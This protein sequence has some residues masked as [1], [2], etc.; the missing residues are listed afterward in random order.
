VTID[1]GDGRVM[2]RT[3]T[4]NSI[5]YV[6]D[7]QARPIDALPGLYS[8]DMFIKKLNAALKLHSQL[9]GPDRDEKLAAWHRAAMDVKEEVTPQLLAP[10]VRLVIAA[11]APPAEKAEK[12]TVSKGFVETP[13]IAS[14]RR[15]EDSIAQ[16]TARNEN[17]LHHQIHAWFA[18]RTVADWSGFNDRVYAQLF[19]TP[20]SDPWL[21][22]APADVFSG[23]ENSGFARR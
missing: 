13:L 14:I 17:D 15:L 4:G 19:L 10:Q 9:N 21:G 2:K 22:L 12:L 5:H 6:L 7:E 11:K 3:I 1:F 8:A 16:D 20:K 18:Q 23:L